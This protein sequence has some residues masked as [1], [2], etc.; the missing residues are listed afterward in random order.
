MF[1]HLNNIVSGSLWLLCAVILLLAGCCC[2]GAELIPLDPAF[3]KALWMQEAS[4][5]LNPKDGDGGRAIGPFQIWHSYWQDAVR[6]DK[7]LGGKYEDCRN[8]NYAKRVVT[9]Y[10]NR[11]ARKALVAKDFEALARRHNGGPTWE[12]RPVA[13]V[14]TKAYW[15]TLKKRL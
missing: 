14:A 8:Y 7:N 6:F 2:K 10:L 4:G 12:K 5:Q 1:K 3:E 15:E 9:A 13:R 11:W